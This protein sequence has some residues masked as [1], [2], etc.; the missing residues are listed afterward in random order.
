MPSTVA[1]RGML[2][3]D[4]LRVIRDRFLTGITAYIFFVFFLLRAAIPWATDKIALNWQFDLTPYHALIVAHFVV[5]LAPFLPGI[6]GGFLLLESREEGTT[7]AL[8]V[9]P[10]SLFSYVMVA[11][12]LLGL[13]AVFLTML[14]GAIIGTALPSWPALLAIALAAAPAGPAFALLIATSANN[15]VQAFAFM[16][17]FGTAPLISVGGFF[18]P[19]P[20]QWLVGIYP[21]FCACKAYWLAE[22]GIGSW[23]FWVLAGL[24]N[25][26]V[27]LVV[28]IRMFLSAAHR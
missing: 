20:A 5:Q 16:K 26:T 25:S 13:S 22:A 2:R 17:I 11:C 10:N 24:I 3:V 23:P 9:A 4:F 1:M 8:L 21:P 14:T 28:L 6:V 7:K 18:L 12:A 27:L 15:K 19:E